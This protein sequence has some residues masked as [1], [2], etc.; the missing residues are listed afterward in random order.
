VLANLD[1]NAIVNNLRA[2]I[3]T[4]SIWPYLILLVWTFLEGETIV[5]FAGFCATDG[6]PWLPLVILS[7]FCGSL[8]SDQ[9]MFFLGRFKGKTFV[10]KRPK[11]QQ[12]AQGVYRILERHQ[13]CL[14]LGFRFLYGLRNITPFAIGMSEVPTRRFIFL[15]V[16]GAAVWAT[17]FAYAGYLFGTVIETYFEKEGKWVVMGVVL[18]VAFIIWVIRQICRRRARIANGEAE[19]GMTPPAAEPTEKQA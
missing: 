15:N 1:I 9:L 4:N 10:A 16:T 14:I 8:I 13:T 11:W 19:A 5:I 6:T 7:A 12:R 2:T 18:A 17:A 3:D